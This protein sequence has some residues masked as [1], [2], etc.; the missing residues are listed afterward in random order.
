MPA[1]L[2]LA[3]SPGTLC[4]AFQATSAK[5]PDVVALRTV[6]DTVTITWRQYRQRVEAIASGLAK[7]GVGPGDAVSL[8]LTNR[9]EFHLCDT[10]VLHA[11]ATPFSIY[12][13]NPPEMIG[14]LFD[15]A[16]NRVV[17]CEKQFL[18]VVLA[19]R[20]CGGKVEHVICVDGTEDGVISLEQ[21]ENDPATDFDF[22]AAWRSVKPDDVL[23]LVYTSGTTGPPKGVELTHRNFIVNAQI[24]D[25]LGKAGASD[26]VISYLPDAHAANRWFTHYLSI[27]HGVQITDLVDA[28]QLL[29]ALIEARPT[30]MLGVPRVWIKLKSG[31]E[32]AVTEESSGK[33]ALVNWAFGVGRKRARAASDGRRVGVA[34]RIQHLAADQLVLSKLRAKLGL[35]QVRIAVTGAAPIPLEVHEFVLS[36][37]ISLCEGY[38]MTECTA[39]ATINRPEH[40]RI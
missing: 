12:N 8:M 22:E 10:A 18:P 39:G 17:I 29:D 28:K 19:A 25:E 31:L 24:V 3:V 15:N 32:A 6:G 33:R 16:G 20:N 11:G 35:D 7:L 38:G 27:L 14:Y 4:E 30:L 1:D 40:I 23:T 26:R 34:D 2:L 36:M 5:H 9:P 13:T 37:G 21:L